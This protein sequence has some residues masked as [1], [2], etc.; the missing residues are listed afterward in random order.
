MEMATPH[1]EQ[2]TAP[3]QMANPLRRGRL[4]FADFRFARTPDGRCSAEVALEWEGTIVRGRG[5]GLSNATVDL[6]VAADATI[7]ALDEF[8]ERRYGFVLL[9]VKAVRAFDANVIIVAVT[10][11]LG[12]DPRQLLG[13]ALVEG[14]PARGAVLAVLNATNRVLGNFIATR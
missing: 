7:Q 10:T 12:Q 2:D 14:D 3:D 6:R 5:S 11:R 1:S 4:R 13:V 9:G 8:T